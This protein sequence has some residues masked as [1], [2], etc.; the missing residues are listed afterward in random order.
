MSNP[1]PS[2]SSISTILITALLTTAPVS[3]NVAYAATSAER[4][5][6]V[7]VQTDPSGTVRDITVEEL[8]SGAEEPTERPS[9]EQPPVIVRVTY[10]LDGKQTDPTSLAGAN[11]HLVIRIDYE[12]TSSSLHEIGGAQERIYTPFV[13]MTAAMLDRDVF[14]HVEVTNG[15]VIEDKGGLAVIGYALPGL[16]ESLGA[17]ADELELDLSEYVEISAD[18]TDLT[19][20]P[21]YTIVTPELFTDLDLD[22]LDLGD[23]DD[24]DELGRAMEQL[25]DGS[26]TLGDALGKLSGGGKQLAGGIAQLKEKLGLLPK[27]VSSLAKGARG[28][29]KGLG[30]ANKAVGT[31]SEGA[32]ELPALAQAAGT[33]LGAAQASV[34]SAGSQVEAAAQSVGK[35]RQTVGD[36]DL[37]GARSAIDGSGSTTKAA[38]DTIGQAQAVLSQASPTLLG[39]DEVAADLGAASTALEGI[40]LDAL[41]ALKDVE[42]VDDSTIDAVVAAIDEAQA[43]VG[44][45]QQDLQAV[46][47]GDGM[48]DISGQLEALNE[49]QRT[50]E[51]HKAT[52]DKASSDLGT[53]I[54]GADDALAALGSAGDALAGTTES[55]EAAGRSVTA[56]GQVAGGLSYGLSGLSEQLPAA[57]EGAEQISEGLDGLSETAP[58]IVKGVSQL[59]EGASALAEGLSATAEGSGKLTEGLSTFNDEGITKVVDALHDLDGDLGSMTDRLDALRD[60]ASAYDSFPA[61]EDGASGSVRFVYKTERIG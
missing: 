17:N 7:R 6:T 23:F 3:S 4:S 34:S 15:R 45:A 41:D 18:V 35:L 53:V 19:L 14:S 5:E 9:D 47:V 55:F 33:S 57:V 61:D 31:M 13:C 21:L 16:R 27:G 11:G 8:L 40:D 50:L 20:D 26:Q 42:G 56:L 32:S 52:L 51:G 22:D 37:A 39:T 58:K 54:G 49:A 38:A 12:N 44:S 25:V 36:I 30:E 10:T 29:A 59:D 1:H 46:A 43:D 24:V 60:A 28:L 48:P 2:W